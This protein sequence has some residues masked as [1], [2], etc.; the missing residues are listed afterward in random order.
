[1]STH[2]TPA[3]KTIVMTGATRGFGRLAAI[4]LLH[5]DPELHLVVIARSNITAVAEE[6]ARPAAIST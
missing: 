4:D 2:T 5:G 1:M 3:T 6:L